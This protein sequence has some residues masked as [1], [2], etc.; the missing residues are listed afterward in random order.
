MSAIEDISSSSSD[1]SDDD[2][3]DVDTADR[4]NGFPTSDS[5]TEDFYAEKILK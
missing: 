1:E 3:T 4:G 2:L 5:G